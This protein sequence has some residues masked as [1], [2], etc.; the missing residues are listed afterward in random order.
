MNK[1]EVFNT[2]ARHLF[3][4]GKW[5]AEFNQEGYDQACKESAFYGFGIPQESDYMTCRYR[6]DDGLKCAIGSL[7]PD[8][9]YNPAMDNVGGVYGLAQEFPQVME[10]LFDITDD[11]DINLG[12]LGALQS[13]HDSQHNWKSTENMRKDLWNVAARYNVDGSIVNTLS[14]NDR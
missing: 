12:F 13:V 8:E 3:I 9:V 11:N 14:F 10:Q 2:V 4:Q 6:T 1:Q 7:I 5:A